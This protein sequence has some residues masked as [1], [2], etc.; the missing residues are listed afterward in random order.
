[1]MRLAGVRRGNRCVDR[2][3]RRLRWRDLPGRQRATLLVVGLAELSLTAT[4]AV[5]LCRRPR[6]TVRGHK[7]L[8]WPAILVQPVGPVAYL[9][10]GRR[11]AG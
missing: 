6:E 7:A 3:S 2:R 1:M 9:I 11:R 8:W 4:A 5:D 10:F